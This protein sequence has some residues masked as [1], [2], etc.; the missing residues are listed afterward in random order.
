MI[1]T[2]AAMACMALLFV[3]FGLMKAADRDDC[4]GRCDGCTGSCDWFKDGKPS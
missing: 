3:A 1:S 2:A 4:D